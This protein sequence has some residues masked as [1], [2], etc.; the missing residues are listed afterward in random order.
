MVMDRTGSHPAPD[1]LQLTQAETARFHGQVERISLIVES[2]RWL[3]ARRT[4]IC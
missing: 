1:F 4:P 3:A 2:R